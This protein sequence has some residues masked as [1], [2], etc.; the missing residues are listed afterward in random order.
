MHHDAPSYYRKYDTKLDIKIKIIKKKQG[1]NLAF[2][3]I[4]G[5]A[6]LLCPRKNII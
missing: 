4:H 1:R 5:G 3:G 6:Q 2:Y